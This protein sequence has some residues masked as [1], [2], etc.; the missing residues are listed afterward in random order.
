MGTTITSLTINT[1]L[2]PNGKPTPNL[3]INEAWKGPDPEE[4][5]TT[6]PGY[7]KTNVPAFTIPG[8]Y[9]AT[10]TLGSD[11]YSLV[12]STVDFGAVETT[13]MD[14]SLTLTFKLTND[15]G[16]NPVVVPGSEAMVARFDIATSTAT[17]TTQPQRS[18]YMTFDSISTTG[19]T[20][21]V[22]GADGSS[23]TLTLRPPPSPNTA[24]VKSGNFTGSIGV[25]SSVPPTNQRLQV[26][27]TLQ[28]GTY[29]LTYTYVFRDNYAASI[30]G[31]PYT[32]VDQPGVGGKLDSI[33]VRTPMGPVP[34]QNYTI[35][36]TA[37]ISVG[38]S[39]GE[40]SEPGV[41]GTTKSYRWGGNISSPSG[42]A[43]VNIAGRDYTL[44]LGL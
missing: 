27:A 30:G 39:G 33:K 17:G 4:R 32:F 20:L 42:T 22:N 41:G 28:P 40:W 13:D 16:G 3:S 43:V 44:S 18:W 5:Y 26:R 19:I 2:D 14:G 36:S 24:T 35:P 7:S 21:V 1:S 10:T 29:P 38:L 12:T 15:A 11:G 31:V 37:R 34:G 25:I 23:R 9:E 8:T 6:F